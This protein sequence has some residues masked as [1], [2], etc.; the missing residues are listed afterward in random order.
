M[1][2]LF[3]SYSHNDEGLRNKLE[4]HLAVLK[5][6]GFIETWHDRRI[7][8]GSPLDPAIDA[9]LE[10]ADVVLL[11]VSSDFLDSD[12]CY[13]RE[14]GRALERHEAGS[15]VVVPVVLR[16]C[17]WHDAPFGKLLATPTDGRPVT[18]WPD[19]DAAFLDVVKA[20]KGALR[21]RGA[22]P[23]RA[24]APRPAPGA[25]EP[26]I[27]TAAGPRS[28][29]LG[30]ARRFTQHDKDEFLHATFEYLAK[31]F[32]NSLAELQAR[33]SGIETRF[34][35]IDANRFTAMAYSH[36][37]VVARCGISLSSGSGAMSGI[38]YSHNN[39]AAFA[40][41]FNEILSVDSDDHVLFLTTLGMGTMRRGGNESSKLT[42]EG[43]AEIY[44]GMFMEGLQRSRRRHGTSCL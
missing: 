5:R 34:R 11:L 28:S 4:K 40:T 32:E 22:A 31:Y 20:V 12:Y 41:A 35:R 30:I 13:E 44:W 14:M 3:F 8:A 18:Q 21:A 37:E 1:A 29:N 39:D 2:N 19:L 25:P 7:M 43:G 38:T 15:C 16:P 10:R 23:S 36:G 17:D 24:V 42:H 26:A 27:A 33:N 6:Q 9:A